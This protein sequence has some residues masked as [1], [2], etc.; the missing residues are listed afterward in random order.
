LWIGR[1]TGFVTLL[2]GLIAMAAR[3]TGPF[4]IGGPRARTLLL[5]EAAAMVLV[6]LAHRVALT[7]RPA[8]SRI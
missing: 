8:R 4:W 3:L 1:L 6:C 2:A 7:P 5:A